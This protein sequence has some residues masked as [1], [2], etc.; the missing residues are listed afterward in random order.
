M[1]IRSVA[2]ALV[3]GRSR[4]WGARRVGNHS[5]PDSSDGQRASWVTLGGGE[6]EPVEAEFRVLDAARSCGV[7]AVRGHLAASGVAVLASTSAPS[8]S[9]VTVQRSGFLSY[10]LARSMNP[11]CGPWPC[12][13][14]VPRSTCQELTRSAPCFFVRDASRSLCG[15]Q[16]GRP[17]IPRTVGFLPHRTDSVGGTCEDRAPGRRWPS[18]RCDRDAAPPEREN[19]RTLAPS[20]RG[21]WAGSDPDGPTA[22]CSRANRPRYRRREGRRAADHAR[23]ADERDTPTRPTWH[24]PTTT[25]RTASAAS[26]DPQR[27]H[28]SRTAGCR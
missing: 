1:G 25:P 24:T 7:R 17:A 11:T 27:P 20:L 28:R 22:R 21:R 5:V 4:P 15:P 3:H 26:V 16:A 18:Q 9:T 12:G 10:H 6:P 19:G 8:R 2:T 14:S 23:T 13:P